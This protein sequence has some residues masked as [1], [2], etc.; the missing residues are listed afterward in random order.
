VEQLTAFL[1]SRVDAPIADF[2]ARFSGRRTADCS[3]TSSSPAAASVTPGAATTSLAVEEVERIA[4]LLRD[5]RFLNMTND[6]T[7][8]GLVAGAFFKANFW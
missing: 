6:C 2:F 7:S 8:F 1:K 5:F 3:A 4:A